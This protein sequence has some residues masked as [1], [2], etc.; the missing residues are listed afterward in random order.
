MRPCLNKQQ[1]FPCYLVLSKI[2]W[3][4]ED[5]YYSSWIMIFLFLYYPS[6]FVE[7]KSTF[8]KYF[9]YD[10]LIQNS[11]GKK[12][13]VY[14]WII[15]WVQ[16]SLRFSSRLLIFESHIFSSL[17]KFQYKM[18]CKPPQHLFMYRLCLKHLLLIWRKVSTGWMTIHYS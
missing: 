1:T 15:E 18:T 16:F 9:C 14:I 17:V 5:S 4:L 7:W 6:N 8:L 11:G 13:A 12:N 10:L 3:I 2:I